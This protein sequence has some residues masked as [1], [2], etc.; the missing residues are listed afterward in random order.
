M[1]NQR[2]PSSGSRANPAS[3]GQKEVAPP[4]LRR[5]CPPSYSSSQLPL[6][7]SPD[8]Q[9]V[10]R[11]DQPRPSHLRRTENRANR[12][13]PSPP[14]TVGA[15]R[16][17]YS[18]VDHDLPCVDRW[19]ISTIGGLRLGH[20]HQQPG[21]VAQGAKNLGHRQIAFDGEVAA[22]EAV[23]QWHSANN[24]FRDMV[25]HSDPTSAIAWVQHSGARLG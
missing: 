2:H 18:A 24:A 23:V 7:T 13:L 3:S 25:I 8:T 9:V 20:Y 15:A 22:I 11:G 1:H 16:S 12:V 14:Y 21:A 17:T 19:I 6:K 10:R 5:L 4:G